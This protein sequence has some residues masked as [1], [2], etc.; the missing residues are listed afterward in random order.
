LFNTEDTVLSRPALQNPSQ[1]SKQAKAEE[2][3]TK[4][5]PRLPQCH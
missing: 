1:T 5:C 3:N 2:E 4:S